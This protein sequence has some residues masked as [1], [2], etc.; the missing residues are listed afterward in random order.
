MRFLA[1]NGL[2]WVGFT[3]SFGTK[4]LRESKDIAL[5]CF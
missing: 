4:A 3:L 1:L 5:L 2:G